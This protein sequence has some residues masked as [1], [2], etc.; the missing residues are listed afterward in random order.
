M[1]SI[2]KHHSNLTERF[3]NFIVLSTLFF[4]SCKI[5]PWSFEENIAVASII[6]AIVAI[7]SIQLCRNLVQSI[8]KSKNSVIQLLLTYATGLVIGTCVMLAIGFN[9]SSMQG[10][11]VVVILTSIMAFFV[12]GTISPLARFNKHI[13]IQ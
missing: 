12:L 7:I 4:I 5:V 3:I 2:F 13:I 8:I 9:I 1:F 11:S 6:Y 10:L